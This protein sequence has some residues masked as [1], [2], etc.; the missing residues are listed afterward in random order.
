MISAGPYGGPP[1][2]VMMVAPRITSVSY[3]PAA[4]AVSR[5]GVGFIWALAV[6]ASSPSAMAIVTVRR[7]WTV[8]IAWRW[9]CAVATILVK[10]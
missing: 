8:W 6:L 2:P 5:G 4:I 10:P 7:R 3:G 1:L 9:C